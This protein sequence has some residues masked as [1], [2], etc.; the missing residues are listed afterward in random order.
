M[1]TGTTM[2]SAVLPRAPV[3]RLNEL[4]DDRAKTLHSLLVQN[5]AAHAVLREPRLL[6]HNHV[7]HVSSSI[8]QQPL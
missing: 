3:H 4:S 2:T 8:P 6:F 7:P 1:N 5:H